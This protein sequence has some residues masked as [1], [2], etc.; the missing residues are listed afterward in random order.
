M[1]VISASGNSINLIKA[2]KFV[3][4]NRGNVIG[5]LG[6]SGGKL[7]KLCDTAVHIPTNDGEYGPVEDSHLIINH[8]L[9]HWFQNKL[10]N[11]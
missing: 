1:L 6:F 8:I 9:A 3:K 2:L 7:K 11:F 10:N 5:L 4:K